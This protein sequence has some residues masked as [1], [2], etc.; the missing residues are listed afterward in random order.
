M[1][2][3][4]VREL[5]KPAA[6]GKRQLIDLYGL[7]S[8][9]AAVAAALAGGIRAEDVA[10]ARRVSLDT[11]RAQVRNL[12]RKTNATNLRDLE[13]IIALVSAV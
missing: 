8:A 6:A 5:A 10:R 13:R 7:T 4:V 9:E 11:V 2:M 3:V 1:A 12:L